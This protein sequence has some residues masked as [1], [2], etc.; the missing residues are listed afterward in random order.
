MAKRYPN[1]E[2]A[3]RLDPG[4]VSEVALSLRLYF[5][6]LKLCGCYQTGERW[7]RVTARDLNGF[8]DLPFDLQPTSILQGAFGNL[9]CLYLTH[10][11]PGSWIRL[12]QRARAIAEWAHFRAALREIY[13]EEVAEK[14]IVEARPSWNAKVKFDYG[15]ECRMRDDLY[16]RATMIMAATDYGG[17]VLFLRTATGPA[18]EIQIDTRPGADFGKML[19]CFLPKLT[20]YWALDMGFEHTRKDA[21]RRMISFPKELEHA[22]V[23]HAAAAC[24]QL[25]KFVTLF[26]TALQPI[27]VVREEFKKKLRMKSPSAIAAAS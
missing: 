16:Q 12:G 24:W 14:H 17:I 20:R 11:T 25:A 21:L 10:D 1:M 5:T 9:P 13:D 22:A 7:L 15:L 19:G 23:V 6:S 8:V 26:G 2:T 4:I 3:M 18:F 27:E